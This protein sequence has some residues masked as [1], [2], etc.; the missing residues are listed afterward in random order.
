MS[1]VYPEIGLNIQLNDGESVL[2]N[3][4]PDST[5]QQNTSR[6]TNSTD[7][8]FMVTV[9]DE[10]TRLLVN[11]PIKCTVSGPL[12]TYSS[13]FLLLTSALKLATLA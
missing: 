3:G 7:N 11:Y 10:V 9:I 5:S 4:V 8:F 12:S 2:L 6:F 13:F 1:P